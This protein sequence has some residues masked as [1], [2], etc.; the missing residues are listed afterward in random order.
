MNHDR[1]KIKLLNKV[2]QHNMRTRTTQMNN[3]RDRLINWRSQ[4]AIRVDDHWSIG[5]Q[6]SSEKIIWVNRSRNHSK[7]NIVQSFGLVLMKRF[8]SC[9]N[10][11]YSI[12]EDHIWYESY[13]K[14]N[15]YD[16]YVMK[17]MMHMLWSI[18]YTT[19]HPTHNTPW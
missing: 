8:T 3:D 7:V 11:L 15:A 5:F 14:K 1:L 4:L 10:I 16:A 19:Y 6:H 12:S 17:H 13:P 18:W 9:Y 2:K